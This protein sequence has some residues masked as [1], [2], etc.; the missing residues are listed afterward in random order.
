TTSPTTSFSLAN[1]T[2][3]ASF[4]I[5]SADQTDKRFT[6]RSNFQGSG[7]S[8]RLSILNGSNS[9]L[10][11]IASSG[12]VGIGTTANVTAKLF[13]N[14]SYTTATGAEQYGLR[15]QTNFLAADTSSKEGIRAQTAA[16]HSSGTIDNVMGVK[17][18]VSNNI[19]GATLTNGFAFWGRVDQN[20]GTLTNAYGVYIAS[21]SGG[22]TNKYAFVSE[23]GA[24]N[25][26]IGTT[27]VPRTLTLRGTGLF[28]DIQINAGATA[29]DQTIFHISNATGD[30]LSFVETDVAERFVIASGS[31]NVGIG[32]T[33]PTDNLHVIST[34]NG[35]GIL[36]SGGI[37]NVELNL[38]NSG[39]GGR[40]YGWDSTSG[41]SGFGQGKLVL[42]DRTA[43][44]AR[45]TVDSSGNVGIGTTGPL[46]ELDVRG[47]GSQVHFSVN[48]SSN[49]GG[50]LVSNVDSQAIIAGGAE[51]TGSDWIARTASISIMEL[52]FGG[53]KYFSS[54]GNTAG[55]SATLTQRLEIT[56]QGNVGIGTASPVAKLDTTGVVI[57]RHL[58]GFDHSV[59]IGTRTPGGI[60]AL[61]FATNIRG[62]PSDNQ[63]SNRLAANGIVIG[64]NF[65]DFGFQIAIAPNATDEA[66]WNV[67][68]NVKFRIQTDGDI[69]IGTTSPAHRLHIRDTRAVANPVANIESFQSSV[70]TDILR[71]GAG[72]AAA[73]TFN[74]IDARSDIDGTPDSEFRVRGDGQIFSDAGT[75]VSSPADVAEN[76]EFDD[77]TVEA[78]DIVVTTDDVRV[79]N[80]YDILNENSDHIIETTMMS[81]LAK[82]D[83]PYQSN[84]VGVVSTKP[85]LLLAGGIDGSPLALSGRVPTKVSLENGPIKPGDLI[86]SSSVPGVGMKAT[87]PGRV[88]GISLGSVTNISSGSYQKMEV[89]MN[90]HWYGGS[91]STGNLA[92]QPI[93][94]STST[95]YSQFLNVAA[96]GGKV[97]I[98]H[99][100]NFNSLTLKSVGEVI[101]DAPSAIFKTI[102][103]K[104][105]VI[106]NGI[107]KTYFATADLF[108]NVDV[109]LMFANW[110]TRNI[111]ITQDADPEIH[112]LF[113]GNG[114]Q[115]AEQSKIDLEDNGN[116]L[117]TYGVDSTR[118]EIQLSG[119][120][121]ISGG[122][123]KI[124]FDY[125]FTSVISD[126]API[127]VLLT[128]TT[129][130]QGQLYV[131]QKTIYGFVV[132]ELNGTSSGKFDW[133]IIARRK[134]FDEDISSPTPTPASSQTSPTPSPT[135]EPSSEPTPSPSP[136]PTPEPSISPT[137]EPTESPSPTP[138]PSA[139]PEPSIEPT[140]EPSESPTPFPTPEPPS[141]PTPSPS[142]DPTPEPTG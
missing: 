7:I 51:W 135:P 95:P 113:S 96:V 36:V 46:Q 63:V 142:P 65:S 12:F 20:D 10:I 17:S 35:G 112:A 47:S 62:S 28:T 38:N 48:T 57:A 42:R 81:I 49:V 53:L 136:D 60:P 9:E 6:L 11:S 125:S 134:G 24:G 1:L 115:A 126:K 108:P 106:A 33:G 8:E 114:A 101:V 122:E 64:H 75:T 43:G 118:G 56:N 121:D 73:T 71:L 26:G 89:L 107:K 120:S 85:G 25:V 45:L 68:D 27:T 23:A 130:M 111:E 76:Y 123:A 22:P 140:P 88:V 105:D 54:T 127:R 100:N 39:T 102:K 97:E 124:F 131:D 18:I 117:A 79:V 69:G 4:D 104:G 15:V 55:N 132:K 52:S 19:A 116:Y 59:E 5:T 77:P 3:T 21:G 2:A 84:L 40:Q 30:R 86:T 78:G 103:A 70:N 50:Y 119:S 129:L 133:L 67:E 98:G 13:T 109:S 99:T 87:G 138:E 83:K 137:P 82:S 74:F 58:P 29:V 93:V 32:T 14:H 91:L 37:D 34:I 92:I 66:V 41:T 80:T 94:A 128:L 90:P 44:A 61:G 141:E 139:T 16:A 110:T 72:P 31:G